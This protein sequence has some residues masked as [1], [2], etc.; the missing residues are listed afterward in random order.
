MA[1]KQQFHI[2]ASVTDSVGIDV[3]SALLINSV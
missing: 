1:L 3:W 2:W